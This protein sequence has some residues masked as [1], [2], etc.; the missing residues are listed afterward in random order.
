[1]FSPPALIVLTFV[2]FATRFPSTSAL[3]ISDPRVRH[4][5][6]LTVRTPPSFPHETPPLVVLI[7]EKVSSIRPRVWKVER[8]AFLSTEK[9]VKV[10]DID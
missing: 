3:A 8:T 2:L 1:M 9:E 7:N 5:Q 4:K 10:K 6:A